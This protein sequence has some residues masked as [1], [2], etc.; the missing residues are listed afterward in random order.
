M[1][2]Q[3]DWR[4][5]LARWWAE[6]SL[7]T[8]LLAV[9]TLVVSLLMTGITFFALNSIQQDVRLSDTR[10]GRDLGLLVAANVNPLVARGDDRALATVAERFWSSSRSLR[11]I[12]FADAEGVIY[13]GIPM[14]NGIANQG[15]DQLLSRRL[16][17]PADL[18]KR[19]DNPLIR[20]HLS[21]DGQVTDVFVPLVDGDRYLGV[22][23]LGINPNETL[24][25]SSAL[26]REVTVAVFISIWVL[27]I[28]GSVFNAL[29]ITAAAGGAAHRRRRLCH[30]H[31]PA[32]GGRAGGVAGGVQHHG[33]TPGGLRR[34]QHRGAAGRPGEAAVPDR[35]HGRWGRAA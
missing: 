8:K 2:T 13:L 25:A 1:P 18:Q 28:L 7:Q 11:Y 19:P 15:E 9:A 17:L 30:P 31:R 29:T 24:L 26:T 12:V 34:G 16:E 27:V 35:H 6:F 22:V 21:P 20:Q 3:A 5:R 33:L 23:A 14:G 10:Y 4:S 32:G